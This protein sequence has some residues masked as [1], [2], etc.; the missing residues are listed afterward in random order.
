M[1]AVFGFLDY[2]GKTSNAV[3]KKLIHYLSVAA[4]VRGTDA[5]GIAYV[6]D[7]SIVTYKKPKPAHKV[8]LFF[9]RGTRSVIGHTRFT[10]QGSEKRNCNNHPFEGHCGTEAFALAHN[11]VLYNDKELC[12]EQH[13]P[14]TPIETD[15][16]IAVQLLEQGQQLDTEKIR[17]TAELVEG[18]FVFTILKNDNTLFLVK[19]NNPLTL[20]HFPALGLYVYASTKSILDNALKRVKLNGKCCE[21]DV[22]EGEI[23]EINSAGNL[24]R[25]AF[26]MRDYIHTMFNPYNWDYAK[27]WMEDEREELLLEYCG[28]FGVSEEEVQLLLEV[29]YDPDEIEELL[30][31]TAA[32]EE[33]INE[34]KAL[35]QCEA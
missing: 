4:E 10:T 2:K 25:N 19:G 18:S 27:W 31:D 34:A 30:M 1:C 29:G 13:L 33:A 28:T 11:G 21:V 17:R 24:S 20:Y 6:R 22:S 8:K 15:S 23:L 9:P 7:S 16:Y 35:L 12:R 14:P 32:M 26:T 3:L 5:T